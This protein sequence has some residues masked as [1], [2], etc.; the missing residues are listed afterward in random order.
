MHT[1]VLSRHGDGAAVPATLEAMVEASTGDWVWVDIDASHA[2]LPDALA[3]A[4][5]LGIDP[6]T[7]AD[8]LADEEIPKFDDYGEMIGLVLHGLRPH[9]VRSHEVHSFLS[10]STLVTLHEGQSPSIE[11]LWERCQASAELASGGPDELLA[12]LADTLTRR[13]MSVV[14]AFDARID[15]LIEDALDA[16]DELLENLTA[17]RRDVS[18]TRKVV[19]PQREA[20]DAARRSDSPLIGD[21]GRRRF[22]EAFDV[23]NRASHGLDAARTALSETL[24]AYRGAEARRSTDLSRVLTIYAAIMLP[25]SLI[26]GVFGMNFVDLP[27]GDSDHG[28]A[29]VMAVMG[30]VTVLSLGMFVAAGWV[31]WPSGQETSNA[32]GRGLVEAARAPAVVASSMFVVPLAP[33]R[34]ARRATQARRTSTGSKTSR[35]TRR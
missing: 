15:E 27:L 16:D 31:R 11:A 13:L 33:V 8:V 12:R 32:L 18:A 35:E 4:D 6:V 22:A 9:A 23:A 19:H 30:T 20:L 17:V 21:R 14:E 25:L 5:L 24:D 34:I 26:A 29:I 28:F 7:L 1:R 2:D 3:I 10:E